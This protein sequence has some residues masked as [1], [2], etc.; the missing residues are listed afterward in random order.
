VIERV[1]AR[2]PSGFL[3]IDGAALLVLG[4]RESLRAS[5]LGCTL[6]VGLGVLFL[7]GGWRLG[8]FRRVMPG[9]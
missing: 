1:L 6:A 8:N 4:I 9:R 3:F 7:V 5:W 2:V